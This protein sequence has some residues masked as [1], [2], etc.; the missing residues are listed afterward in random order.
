MDFKELFRPDF[1]VKDEEVTASLRRSPCPVILYGAAEDVGDR[2]VNKL[3]ACGLHLAGVVVDEDCPAAVDTPALSGTDVYTP[4]GADKRF[5]AYHVLIGFVG[6]YARTG[7]IARKF[8][9]ARSVDYLSELFDMEIITPSFVA[10]HREPLEALYRSLGDPLSQDSFVAYLLAKT[11]QDM[12][13]IPPFFDRAQYFPAGLFRLTDHE[14]Y[15]DCGA[16]TGDTVADF[17]HATG[18]RYRHI[19]AAEPD[20]S[21]FRRLTRFIA[22]RRLT[23]IEAVNRG[24]YSFAGRLPFQAE[25]NMLSMIA[26]EA[27]QSIEVD[28]VDRIAAGRPVTYLK[29]DVEGAELM[30]LRGAEQT[31]RTH[32]PLLGISIYHR[33]RDLIDI[34]AFIHSLVPEYRFHFRVH[35]KLAID[36]VLY[37]VAPHSGSS[38]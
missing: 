8:R 20:P 13:Y 33:Q 3:S 35:K 31:L 4:A 14:S 5:A 32:R 16:F 25:G 10:A 28:T 24:I 38:S 18:G 37:A 29:M 1:T 12:R 7:H 15:F 36:T 17:L 9:N 23:G 19:W 2:I 11:R 27:A 26:A 34:P 6:G 21:N 22:D 30:A